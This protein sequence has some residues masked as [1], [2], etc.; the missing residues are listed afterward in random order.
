MNVPMKKILIA[1]A[2][3]LLAAVPALR[4]DD[5]GAAL[6][7]DETLPL[8]L[9]LAHPD[10]YVGKKVRVEGTVTEV[11]QMKG[12]WMELQEGPE[13]KIRVKVDDGVIVFP[14][15]ATG[16]KAIAEG[17]VESVPM[18]RESY[19]AWRQHEAEERGVKF[20][21]ATVGDGPFQILQLRGLGA[22]I[23]GK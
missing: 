9:L 1:L 16:K 19:V 12:C 7:L 22:R 15:T 14:A 6:T 23:S 20:D 18:T 13:A 11:C 4:A 21:A 2:L 10:Q 8:P 5:Y 17:V 3:T